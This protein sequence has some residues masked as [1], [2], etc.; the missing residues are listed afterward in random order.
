MRKG[1][2]T[3]EAQN[4]LGRHG[5]RGKPAG[6][7]CISDAPELPHGLEGGEGHP[8]FPSLRT[9]YLAFLP[10]T[11]LDIF[12]E[13]PGMEGLGGSP[14][15]VEGG[16]EASGLLPCPLTPQAPCSHTFC[17]QQRKKQLRSSPRGGKG[18]VQQQE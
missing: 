2:E 6:P 15:V 17:G 5:A 18:G 1:P 10:W 13:A 4:V 8:A 7:M 14:P 3:G 12:I 16:Q 11:Q 9:C